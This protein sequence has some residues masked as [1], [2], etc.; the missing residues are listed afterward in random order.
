[1]DFAKLNCS[2]RSKPRL[3]FLIPIASPR[4]A[5]DWCLACAYFKQTLSSI[6]NSTAGNYCVVVAGHEPPDFQLP[7][8]PRFKFLSLHHAVPPLEDGFWVAAVKDKMIKV[9]AAWNYAKS[10]W[11]PQYVMKIDWDDLISSRLVDWLN[12]AKDAAGYCI[13]HGW[14]W[15]SGSRYVITCSESFDLVC[16]TCLIIRSDLADSQGPFLNSMEGMK[17]D[18]TGKR[19]EASD[20]RALVP[21]AGIGSL[22]LNDN[23]GRA[24]AQFRYLGHQLATVP[25]RAA[26]YRVRSGQ[27]VSQRGFR[28][29]SV[30]WFVGSIRRTR[31]ITQRLRKEFLL[32]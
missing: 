24:E 16:G 31:F 11:N 4:R 29:H 17:L 2:I 28:I 15:N 23:H 25:F 21:G 10:R 3:A 20:N 7:Q 30:R 1:M 26:V 6:F 9:G 18:E 22:L 5:K 14:V 32:D 19:I 13:K 12:T 8:D 27:S